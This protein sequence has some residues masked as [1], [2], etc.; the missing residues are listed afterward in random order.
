MASVAVP[1]ELTPVE[2][3]LLDPNVRYVGD[4]P[5]SAGFPS[6]ALLPDEEQTGLVTEIDVPFPEDVGEGAGG[7]DGPAPSGMFTQDESAGADAVAHYKPWHVWGEDWGI[8]FFAQPF[9]DFVAATAALSGTPYRQ[10]EPY[11]MRQLLEHELTHFEF[12]VVGT[13]L[14]AIYGAP[15]YRSYLFQGFSSPTRWTGLPWAK[16]PHPGPAEEA[17]ATWREVR[18]SRRKKPASPRGYQAAASKLADASPAGYN[19]WRCADTANAHLAGLVTATVASLIAHAPHVVPP[20]HGLDQEDLGDVPVYWRGDPAVIPSSAPAKDTTR[21][22]PKR[23]EKWLKKNQAE[24]DR[25]RG[26]GSH[27]PV[28]LARSVRRLLNQSRSRSGGT[29]QSN[30]DPV[31]IHEHEG[32]LPSDSGQPRRPLEARGKCRTWAVAM[33]ERERRARLVVAAGSRSQRHMADAL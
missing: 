16:G 19:A 14:E 12:E 22:T 21:P 17:I 11:V 9:R 5:P 27:V 3:D 20:A 13:K 25:D 23:L 33:R 8:Y 18:Y 31:R 1:G 7:D 2:H 6:W 28:H 32:L 26:K 4:A 30:C 29:V 24:I 10:L 15:L